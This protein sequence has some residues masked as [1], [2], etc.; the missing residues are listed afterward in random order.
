MIDRVSHFNQ[1][2]K[3][4]KYHFDSTKHDQAGEW[5]Q[6]LGRFN[7]SW[8]A[9]ISDLVTA[10]KKVNW[11]NVASIDSPSTVMTP[12]RAQRIKS[13]EQDVIQGGGDPEMTLVQADT[14]FSRFPIFKKMTDYFGLERAKARAHIQMTGQVFNYHLDVYPHHADAPV[15]QVMRVV[16]FLQDWEPGHFYIYGTHT[17]SHWKAGDFHTFKWQDVP[18]GTANAGLHPRVS[19]IITGVKTKHT[20]DIL[21]QPF[22]EVDL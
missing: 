16:I 10:S 8:Q 12:E 22:T 4:S 19:I 21:S 6:P 2:K 9:E 13:R 14:D 3:H 11:Q 17:L 1:Q 15:E 20:L 18:H 5:F 7:G